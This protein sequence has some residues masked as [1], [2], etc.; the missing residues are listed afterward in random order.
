MATASG[1][2]E[3]AVQRRGA[4]TVDERHGCDSSPRRKWIVDFIVLRPC[5]PSPGPEAATQRLPLQDVVPVPEVSEPVERVRIRQRFHVKRVISGNLTSSSYCVSRRLDGLCREPLAD[6]G[7]GDGL[8]LLT[9]GA[10]VHFLCKHA[11]S[12]CRR[13]TWPHWRSSCYHKASVLEAS[14]AI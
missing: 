9:H 7:E 10:H 2:P 11:R 13:A 14:W 5:R 12:T 4:Q 1:E 6:F 3:R 8:L